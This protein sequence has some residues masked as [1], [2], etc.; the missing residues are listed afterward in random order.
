MPKPTPKKSV[1]KVKS[2]NISNRKPRLLQVLVGLAALLAIVFVGTMV[3][4]K[5]QERDVKAKAAAFQLRREDYSNG[6]YPNGVRFAICKKGIAV[7]A[8]ATLD[9]A[10]LGGD[11]V[12]SQHTGS[13]YDK[14]RGV[15]LYTKNTPDSYLDK[16]TTTKSNS[17]WFGRDPYYTFVQNTPN[18]YKWVQIHY[19]ESYSDVNYYSKAIHVNYIPSC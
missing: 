19:W 8:M 12:P 5:L 15:S 14:I 3:Y 17:Y 11:K 18:L 13:P 4:T 7:V 9:P 16:Y 1:S 10:Y 2:A 6:K